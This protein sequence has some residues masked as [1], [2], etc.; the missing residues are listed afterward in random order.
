V[1]CFRPLVAY[2][3]RVSGEVAVGYRLAGRGDKLELPC[4]RCVGCKLD[5]ARA[6]SV[7]IGHEA[8]LYDKSLFVTFDYRPDAL[9]SLSLEYGDFQRFLKRLRRELT[10]VSVAP[11]GKKPIRFFVAGEYGER[12]GRPHWHAI[13]FNTWFPDA[14]RFH[15]GTFRSEMAERLWGHGNVVIGHV[16]PA[17]AAYVA[18]YTMGKAHKKAEDYEE[19]LVNPLTGELSGRRPEFNVMSRRPGIGAW[20]YDRFRSDLWNG[21]HAVQ[22]GKEYKVPRYYYEK[23]RG[24]DPSMAEEVAYGRFLRA[25]EMPPEESTPERRAVREEVAEARFKFYSQREH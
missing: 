2:R 3:E 11:N 4:G 19:D 16:T 7:R 9:R 14:V 24:E 12:Y 21:D 22:D 20:W 15:N 8:A 13:L 23:L 6:W 5:R 10:G 1:A 18:G 25:R 17:S